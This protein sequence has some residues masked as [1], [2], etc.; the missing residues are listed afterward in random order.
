MMEWL[1]DDNAV[2]NSICVLVVIG[3]VVEGIVLAFKGRD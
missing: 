2:L 3:L 1:K